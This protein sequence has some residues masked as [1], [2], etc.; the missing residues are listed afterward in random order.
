MKI[1][2][3]K[4]QLETKEKIEKIAEAMGIDPLWASAMAMTESSLGVQK[5]S[6]TGC[7]GVFQMSTIAMRDLHESMRSGTDNTVDIACGLAFL[8]LLLK[9]HKTIKKATEKFC[10]PA[11]RDFYFDR[12]MSYMKVLNED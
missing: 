6:P 5:V 12:M 1:R 3:I 7:L 2:L 8:Y 9:R 4:S 11:D 10:A